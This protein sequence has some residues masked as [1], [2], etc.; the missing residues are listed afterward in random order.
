MS[1]QQADATVLTDAD[2]RFEI[3]GCP[4]LQQ[5]YHVTAK[6]PTGQPYFAASAWVPEASGLGPLTAN[7]ELVSGIPLSGRVTDQATQKPPR[8]GLV[9]YYPLFPNPYSGRI[10]NS[11]LQPASSAVIQP[12]GSYRLTVLAGPGVV[13]VAASPRDSYA[14]ALVREQDFAGFLEDGIKLDRRRRLRAVCGVG[15]H[16]F[17]CLNKYSALSLINLDEKAEFLALDFILQP[18]RTLQ[19]TVVGPDG[20]PVTGVKVMGL[21]ALPED[22]LLEGSSFTVVGLN[23]CGA[24]ALFFRHREKG[25]GKFMTILG[26]QTEPLT[27]QLDPCGSVLGRLVHNDGKPAPGVTVAFFGAY[28]REAKGDTDRQ[29]RFRVDGLVPGQK[30]SLTPGLS[31]LQKDIGEVQVESGRSKDLG[32]LALQ[33]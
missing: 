19:G 21:G 27:V 20:M 22:E 16:G 31:R 13:C 30:Y 6:P 9:E 11:I 15:G 10:T 8:A 7:F 24:R 1:T 18:A 3:R 2:G 5:G 12:D 23:P 25:L 32:D 33:H 17:L 28:G 29:G 26:D 14:V 4:K